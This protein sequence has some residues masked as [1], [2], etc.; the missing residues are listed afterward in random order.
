MHILFNPRFRASRNSYLHMYRSQTAVMSQMQGGAAVPD[1]PLSECRGHK[2]STFNL[3]TMLRDHGENLQSEK[4]T[5]KDMGRQGEG[6]GAEISTLFLGR[7]WRWRGWAL[8]ARF[9]FIVYQALPHKV[10][11]MQKQAGYFP[12]QLTHY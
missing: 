7:L 3:K 9:A 11:R 5:K 1:A 6:Q 12:L 4:S 8:L 2:S 10:P